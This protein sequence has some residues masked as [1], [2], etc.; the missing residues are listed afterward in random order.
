MLVCTA[1]AASAAIFRH[2]LFYLNVLFFYHPCAHIH[3]HTHVCIPVRFFFFPFAIRFFFDTCYINTLP[4]SLTTNC[5]AP[6]VVRFCIGFFLFCMFL[7]VGVFYCCRY[8]IVTNK[9]MQW[10]TA[11]EVANAAL[12]AATTSTST[13]SNKSN[14]PQKKIT[15]KH[16]VWTGGDRCC[17]CMYSINLHLIHRRQ[18]PLLLLCVQNEHFHFFKSVTNIPGCFTYICTQMI[19]CIWMRQREWDRWTIQALRFVVFR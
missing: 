7:N 10:T 14:N 1:A 18:L 8:S 9:H 13:S 4:L 17:C 3:T 11:P 12:A 6:I 5:S 19:A 15:R 16:F 2:Y